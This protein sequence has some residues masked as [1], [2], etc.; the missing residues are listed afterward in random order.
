MLNEILSLLDAKYA[1]TSLL[2]IFYVAEQYGQ[3]AKHYG[4]FL[5]KWNK[6]CIFW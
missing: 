4:L 3:E 1:Q 2:W 5:F 6:D